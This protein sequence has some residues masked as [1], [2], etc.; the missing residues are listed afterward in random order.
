MELVALFS[1]SIAMCIDAFVVSMCKGVSIKQVTSRAAIIVGAWF[2]T[3]HFLMPVIGHYC[4]QAVYD[5]ISGFDH[6][7]LLAVFS[8]LGGKLIYDAVFDKE[9]EIDK[10]LAVWPMFIMS[11]GVSLDALG[12][13]I[14]FAVEKVEV[15]WGPSLMGIMAGSLSVI[16]M[17]IGGRFGM[18]YGKTASIIGGIVLIALGLQTVYEHLTGAA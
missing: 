8:Y 11:V 10:S 3:F 15:I 6:W 9:V 17:F 12:A 4:G 14:A 1:F 2:G 7:I 13:G 18:R 16:G 5:Y